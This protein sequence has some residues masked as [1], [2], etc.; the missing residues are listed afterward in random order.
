MF[1]IAG[2]GVVGNLLCLLL[3]LAV[4]FVIGGIVGLVFAMVAP[5]KPN[6][7]PLPPPAATPAPQGTDNAARLVQLKQLHEQGVLTDDEYARKKA[8]LLAQL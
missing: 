5:R 1:G 2:Y 4:G 8:E 3:G 7:A 6:R